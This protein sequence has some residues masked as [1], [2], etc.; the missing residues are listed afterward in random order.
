[1]L[2]FDIHQQKKRTHTIDLTAIRIRTSVYECNNF[3]YFH[4]IDPIAVDI[5]AIFFINIFLLFSD[6]RII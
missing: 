5:Y 4:N 2:I 3:H 1:M 6:G